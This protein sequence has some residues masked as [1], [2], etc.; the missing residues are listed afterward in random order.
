MENECQ[1]YREVKITKTHYVGKSGTEYSV[2]D[3]TNHGWGGY[4]HGFQDL[5]YDDYPYSI[6][7]HSEYSFKICQEC[8]CTHKK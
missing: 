5:P 1:L 3:Y 7:Y 6:K 2:K 8:N 4:K